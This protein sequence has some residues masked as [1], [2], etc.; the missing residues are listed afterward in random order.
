MLVWNV[1]HKPLKRIK[2]RNCSKKNLSRFRKIFKTWEDVYSDEDA[3]S[4]FIVQA[5]NESCPMG[6]I[7]IKYNNRHEWI[8]RKL[9]EQIKDRETLYIDSVKH[10]TEVNIVVVY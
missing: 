8:S 2:K 10:P 4:G 7:K 5:F 9:K 1:N 3:Q 6:T